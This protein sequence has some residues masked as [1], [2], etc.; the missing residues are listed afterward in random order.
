MVSGSLD[1]SLKV[2]DLSATKAALQRHTKGDP[3]VGNRGVCA[4]TLVGH[5]V[6]RVATPSEYAGPDVRRTQD[7]VLSVGV[8]PDG[9]WLVSGSKDRTIQFWNIASGQAMMLLQGHK[10]SGEFLTD[11]AFYKR[12]LKIMLAN[13]HLHRPRQE[14]WHDGQRKRRLSSSSL[15]L[16][17]STP[18]DLLYLFYLFPFHNFRI[19]SDTPLPS[20][21]G[22]I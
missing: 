17:P 21:L 5:K 15:V 22:I 18:V 10:N 14:R 16:Q 6:S 12:K 1:R 7:Y 8:T 4:S 3:P 2:W 19:P 20:F 13:S 9:Q 11:D